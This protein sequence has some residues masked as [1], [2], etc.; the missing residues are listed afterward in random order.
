MGLRLRFAG[1][2]KPPSS[3]CL[4]PGSKQHSI[5][6]ASIDED[7]EHLRASV[8]A[9]VPVSEESAALRLGHFDV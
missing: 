2:V 8:R 4:A 7:P 1:L 6:P 5:E 3:F 9:P